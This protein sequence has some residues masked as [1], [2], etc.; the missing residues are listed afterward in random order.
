MNETKTKIL[1]LAEG[2]T[3]THGFNGFSY[4]DLAE[5]VGVKHSSIHYHFKTKADLAL[6]LVARIQEAHGS[7]FANLES[8]LDDPAERLARVV[9]FFQAYV[10]EAKF[11]MCGMMSAEL[12][13]VSPEVRGRLVNYFDAFQAWVSN[14]FEELGNEDPQGLALSFVSA[15]EGSLLLARLLG[16]P[17][18]VTVALRPFLSR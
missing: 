17:G 13:S 8:E 11:C 15:L 12:R 18:V 6:A 7:A 3:Q 9:E 4:L 14:Q 2:L 1:D 10:R 16:D 5:G